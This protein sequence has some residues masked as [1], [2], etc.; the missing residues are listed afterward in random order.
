MVGV[1]C[2]QVPTVGTCAHTTPVITVTFKKIRAAYVNPHL[3]L[4]V[5]S[6]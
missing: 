2:T 5:K 6:D 3:R 1:V 4:R